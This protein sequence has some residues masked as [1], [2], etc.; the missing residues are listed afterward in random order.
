M[1]ASVNPGRVRP[2]DYDH[3]KLYA[4]AQVLDAPPA[5]VEHAIALNTSYI[6]NYDQGQEGACVGFGESWMMSLLNRR[7]YDARWLYQQARAA[8][9]IEGEDGATLR[10]GARVLK[11]TGHRRI[12]AGRTDAPALAEGIAAYRWAAPTRTGIDEVRTAIAAGI[13]VAFGIDWFQGDYTPQRHNNEFWIGRITGQ[14]AGGH[15]ICAFAAS[16]ARQAFRLVNS[17]GA[18]YPPVWISYEE[19]LRRLEEGG[20][21]M[22]V[23]D[24]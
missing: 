19:V 10:G 9:P 18:S 5:Q 1:T 16:D 14:V 2:A 22:L 12:R 23:T 3:V 11:A 17:W 15:C 20:E 8:D 7:F 24:R 6:P 13:P 4:A 21:A